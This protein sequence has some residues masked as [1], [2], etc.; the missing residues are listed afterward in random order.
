MK[1]FRRKINK[2][3]SSQLNIYMYQTSKH[4]QSRLL[5]H[6][7]QKLYWSLRKVNCGRV[8]SAYILKPVSFWAEFV[9]KNRCISVHLVSEEVKS[10]KFDNFDNSHNSFLWPEYFID[11]YVK[12][13]SHARL[14]HPSCVYITAQRQYTAVQKMRTLLT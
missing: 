11:F 5:C 13:D 2:F 3:F 8:Y 10:I 4:M 14:R 9:N 7:I 1:K 12:D 6:A